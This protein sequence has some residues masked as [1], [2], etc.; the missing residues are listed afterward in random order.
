ML[1]DDFEIRHIMH[2]A[3]LRAHRLTEGVRAVGD[4]TLYDQ[5][6]T[7]VES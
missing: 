6:S 5:L 1:I 3:S 2:D 7:T 4:H